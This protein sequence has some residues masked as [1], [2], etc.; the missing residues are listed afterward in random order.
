VPILPVYDEQNTAA[1]PLNFASAQHIGFRGGQNPM[2]SL[3]F[4]N[5]RQKSRRTL[6]NFFAQ[7][8]FIPNKLNFRTT[9]NHSLEVLNQRDVALPYF[10]S[11]AFQ[12][13]NASLT[14]RAETF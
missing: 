13:A 7:I 4:N 2:P 8:D 11:D 12:R 9:Y 6:A 3:L 5:N 1:W 10:I 14:K